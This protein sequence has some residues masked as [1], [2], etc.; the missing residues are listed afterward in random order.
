LCLIE[1]DTGKLV[2]SRA[3]LFPIHSNNKIM[4]RYMQTADEKKKRK[5]R[6]R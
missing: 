5:Y 3:V 6:D 2:Y 4:V 1:V